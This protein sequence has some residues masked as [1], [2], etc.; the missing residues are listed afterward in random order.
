MPLIRIV[1]SAEPPAAAAADALLTDLSALLAREIGKPESYVMT[2]L[3]PRARMTFGGTPAPACFAE[4]MNVGT[5]APELT[6]KLSAALGDSA[7]SASTAVLFPYQEGEPKAAS[8]VADGKFNKGKGEL[9]VQLTDRG[10]RAQPVW[11]AAY[12][13]LRANVVFPVEDD[14]IEFDRGAKIT[15]GMFDLTQPEAG[16]FTR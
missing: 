1:T 16:C 15:A 2:C 8:A 3:E 4:V 11:M 13:I 6:R 14:S 10:V 9:A 12:A 5:L 7:K